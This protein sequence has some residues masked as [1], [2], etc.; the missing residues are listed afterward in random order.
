[1]CMHESLSEKQH[2]SHTDEGGSVSTLKLV[3]PR[4]HQEELIYSD[5]V[6]KRFAFLA[7]SKAVPG[8]YRPLV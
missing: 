6:L 8:A 4:S 2:F 3:L 1:M 7:V 5:F